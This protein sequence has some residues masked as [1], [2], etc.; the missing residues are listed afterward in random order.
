[1]LS[2]V[3][4]N[5]VKM[6]ASDTAVPTEKE[7]WESVPR[8]AVGRKPC[9]PRTEG[10]ETGLALWPGGWKGQPLARKYSFQEERPTPS[11]CTRGGEA[12][13]LQDRFLGRPTANTALGEGGP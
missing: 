13:D 1:M 3:T 8:S 6:K 4:L 2:T 12:P 5:F 10:T 7:A 11:H 9:P